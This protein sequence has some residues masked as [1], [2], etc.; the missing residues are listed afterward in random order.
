MH[1]EPRKSF[2]C[3]AQK[4]NKKSNCIQIFHVL[5]VFPRTAIIFFV[6]CYSAMYTILHIRLNFDCCRKKDHFSTRIKYKIVSTH[7]KYTPPPTNTSTTSATATWRKINLLS[8]HQNAYWTSDLVADV[9]RRKSNNE[10]TFS[11][12]IHSESWKWQKTNGAKYNIFHY[13]SWCFL[14]SLLCH[15]SGNRAILSNLGPIRL[16]KSI[17]LR[18]YLFTKYLTRL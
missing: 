6:K 15:I 1:F 3:C 8:N 12:C 7:L 2:H 11:E 9:V 17:F 14:L 16:S 4:I 13:Y 5:H 18:Y 10:I